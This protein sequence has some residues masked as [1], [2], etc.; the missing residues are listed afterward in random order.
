MVLLLYDSTGLQVGPAGRRYSIPIISA[1]PSDLL[2]RSTRFD[3][4]IA[5]FFA[6]K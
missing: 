6:L 1:S 3:Q 4:V 5:L 2:K